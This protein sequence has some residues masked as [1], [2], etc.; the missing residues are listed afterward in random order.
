MKLKR[1]YEKRRP[2][3][4]SSAGDYDI[5]YK[6]VRASVFSLVIHNFL[7]DVWTSGKVLLLSINSRCIMWITFL[8]VKI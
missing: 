2:K 3:I 8:E 5:I 1:F 7:F 4:I 6:C